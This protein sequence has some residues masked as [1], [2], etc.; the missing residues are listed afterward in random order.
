MHYN[1]IRKAFCFQD[2]IALYYIINLEKE[3]SVSMAIIQMEK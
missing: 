1:I 3:E 2:T